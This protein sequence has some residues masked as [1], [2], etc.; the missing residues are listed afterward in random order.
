M[1]PSSAAE[2]TSL[3][4]VDLQVLEIASTAWPVRT[5]VCPE[6]P[7]IAFFVSKE[8]FPRLLPAVAA[9]FVQPTPALCL[10][11]SLLL[12]A[13]VSRVSKALPVARARV[14]NLASTRVQ[15][16]ASHA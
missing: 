15:E 7:P 1:S 12:I 6:V 13:L 5:V 16:C 8:N 11:A 10:A 2:S 3:T 14:A 9:S 4:S